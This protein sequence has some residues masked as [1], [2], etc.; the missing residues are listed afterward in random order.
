MSLRTASSRRTI[1]VVDDDLQFRTA[2]VRLLTHIGWAARMASDGRGALEL[3]ME[4]YRPSVIVLDHD[5]PV[6]SGSQCLRAIRSNQVLASIP[7]VCMSGSA[8]PNAE[9]YFLL[10]PFE[11]AALFEMLDLVTRQ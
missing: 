7:V 1:L 11:P 2:M 8:W 6:M 3:L 10:K 5:M 4:G 9:A